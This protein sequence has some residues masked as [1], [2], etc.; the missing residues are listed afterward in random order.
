MKPTFKFTEKKVPEISE[1]GGKTSNK[2][3][4]LYS[5]FQLED[6]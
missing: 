6:Y 2:G 4:L 1:V 5:L 3:Y